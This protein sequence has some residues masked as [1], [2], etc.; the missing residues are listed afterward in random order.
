MPSSRG[1]NSPRNQTCISCITGGFFTHWATWEAQF[2]LWEKLNISN[3]IPQ[4]QSSC[5]VPI[6]LLLCHTEPCLLEVEQAF[7][8]PISWWHHFNHGSRHRGRAWCLTPVELLPESGTGRQQGP[9]VREGPGTQERE[10]AK[11]SLG[12]RLPGAWQAWGPEFYIL[13]TCVTSSKFLNLLRYLIC[14][15]VFLFGEFPGGPVIRIWCFQ[16]HCLGS[17]P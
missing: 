2:F 7:V 4:S 17:I 6:V 1:S 12:S 13:E 5:S 8:S 14:K 10:K 16:C 3:Q 11:Q 15:N 9:E